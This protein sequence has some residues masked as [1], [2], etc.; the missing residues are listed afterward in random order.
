[1]SEQVARGSFS[2]AENS[3]RWGLSGQGVRGVHG[4]G[5]VSVGKRGVPDRSITMT[6]SALEF[7]SIRQSSQ[8]SV[9]PFC[10][11]F[12]IFAYHALQNH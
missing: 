10:W 12:A 11:H 8:S 5:R 6:T 9:I 1:M 2:S 3:L 4:W 7:S